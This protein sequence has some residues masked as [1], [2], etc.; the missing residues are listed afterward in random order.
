MAVEYRLVF[1]T[2]AR[3]EK[4]LTIDGTTLPN[5]RDGYD[6]FIVEWLAGRADV[7]VVQSSSADP[8]NWGYI[9]LK[10]RRPV[11]ENV[12]LIGNRLVHIRGGFVSVEDSQ[13]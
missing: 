6:R 5:V 10:T 4:V 12:V 8:A 2:V 3:V 9:M 7:I 13:F 1:V 11:Q